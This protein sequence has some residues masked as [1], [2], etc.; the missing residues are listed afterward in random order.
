MLAHILKAG[1]RVVGFGAGGV[2]FGVGA[3][4]VVVVLRGFG[5]G[6]GEG[7]VAG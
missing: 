2:M 3:E 5:D 7:V 1:D 6:E 4:V